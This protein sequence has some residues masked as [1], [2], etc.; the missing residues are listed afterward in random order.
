MNMQSRIQL[1]SRESTAEWL[2]LGSKLRGL[3]SATGE[4]QSNNLPHQEV[5]SVEKKPEERKPEYGKPTDQ[6]KKQ[7]KKGFGHKKTPKK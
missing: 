1:N 7:E 6:L 3:L 2:R 4:N 5:R